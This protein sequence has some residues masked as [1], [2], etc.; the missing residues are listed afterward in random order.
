MA[1]SKKSSEQLIIEKHTGCLRRGFHTWPELT[2]GKMPALGDYRWTADLILATWAQA[3]TGK[4]PRNGLEYRVG[5]SGGGFDVLDFKFLPE[6]QWLP[7]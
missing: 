4:P 5:N 3:E 2:H 6:S 1:S 7:P